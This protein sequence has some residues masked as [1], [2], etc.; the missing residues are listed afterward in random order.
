[1]APNSVVGPTSN[2]S[3][4][5]VRTFHCHF[6]LFLEEEKG[7]KGEKKNLGRRRKRKRK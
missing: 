7:E 5:Q 2:N 6:I 1:V 3:K 4:L